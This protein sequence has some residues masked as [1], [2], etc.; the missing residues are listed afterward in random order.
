[1]SSFS[2]PPA[3]ISWSSVQMVNRSFY[4]LYE[5]NAFLCPTHKSISV[6]L[7]LLVHPHTHRLTLQHFFMDNYFYEF[8]R[9][10]AE[11][12][13]MSWN[14]THIF[15]HLLCLCLSW[16]CAFMILYSSL[17]FSISLSQFQFSPSQ[18]LFS[19]SFSYNT[20]C[21]NSNTVLRTFFN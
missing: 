15:S 2:C 3:L 21:I 13:A 14:F 12:W 11:P 1:M 5:I 7:V 10:F 9:L 19:F 4:A 16:L 17:H 20:V 6:S 18:F 8:I